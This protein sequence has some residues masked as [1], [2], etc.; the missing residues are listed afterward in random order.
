M[1]LNVLFIVGLLSWLVSSF[2][3]S[4]SLEQS[5]SLKVLNEQ[6]DGV[7]SF[8]YVHVHTLTHI[9]THRGIFVGIALYFISNISLGQYPFI[10]REKGKEVFCRSV[11]MN[12]FYDTKLFYKNLMLICSASSNK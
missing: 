10:L 8:T 2:M 6:N 4:P 5:N 9:H 11:T 7:Y 12:I 1:V 3:F